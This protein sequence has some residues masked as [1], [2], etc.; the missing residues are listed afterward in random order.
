VKVDFGALFDASP[1]AY[2]A[3]DRNLRYVAANRSYLE[4]TGSTLE[5][6]IGVHLFERFPHDPSDPNNAPAVR[7]R[8]SLEQVLQT[9]KPDA[10][11]FIRYRLPASAAGP[12]RDAFWSAT[13]TPIFDAQG[14]VAYVL[15]HT[16]NVSRLREAAGFD[17][18][19]A[20][21]PTQMVQQ[22][23]RVLDDGLEVAALL[24]QSP[25][26][27]AFLSGPTHVFTR[28]NPAYQRLIGD[29]EIIG[30]TVDQALPEIEE[31]GFV[32]IL[33]EVFRS[34]EPFIGSGIRLDLA[35]GPGGELRE[36]YVDFVYQPIRDETLQISGVFVHGSDVTERERA[37]DAARD[38]QRV[39]EQASRLKDEFLATVSHELRTPLNAMLGWLS[40]LRSG[41][42]TPENAERALETIERN[43][44]SQ[45]HLIEDL[46]DIGRIVSGH[47]RM[48][49]DRLGVREAIDAAIDTVRPAAVSKEIAI[50]V[51]ED[52][53]LTVM[54]DPHRLQQI[55]W[56]LLSN[57]VKFTP[58]GGVVQVHLAAEGPQMVLSVADDGPGVPDEFKPYAFDRFR[59]HDQEITRAQGGM[60]LGLAIAKQ[61]V[62][63]HGGSITVG[64]SALGGALFEVRMPLASLEEAEAPDSGARNSQVDAEHPELFGRRI[65]LVEDE[66]DTR[67]FVALLLE[68]N[69]AEVTRS[70]DPMES[71]GVVTSWRPDLIISDIGMPGMDGYTFIRQVRG[72]EPEEGGRT[73][74]LALTAYARP[75]DRAR[76]LRAGFQ[77][78]VPKPIE[79]IELIE[80][81]AS[82]LR[83]LQ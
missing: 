28:T 29:R 71:L 69:G 45:L 82:L 44:R 17:W 14:E 26:F 10:L 39:A 55:A 52:Q 37:L 22:A 79:P 4:T 75:E 21:R 40:L 24:E 19:E 73:L 63:L 78:H 1:N 8:R 32:R 62:E 7:L 50:E 42:L 9:G 74:A 20:I 36:H 80:A 51:R 54:G 76:A 64:D 11:P 27:M 31:Q 2:M 58:R 43:A 81:V 48:H 47:L 83:W 60:G 49:V 23:F 30:L 65:L 38:A 72:L 15:Q 33:D 46:L 66:E 56:N 57:A 5:E 12:E 67:D 18:E 61:L 41:E 53:S 6:L 59:Q 3:L 35:S 25:G 16:M 34:G 70:N 77:N 68:K 13:H